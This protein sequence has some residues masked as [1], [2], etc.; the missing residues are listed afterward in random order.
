LLQVEV[1]EVEHQVE[2]VV[3]EVIVHHFQEEQ[4]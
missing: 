2:V 1:E 4:N 3:Q